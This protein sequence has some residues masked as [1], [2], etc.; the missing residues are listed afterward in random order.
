M[1][2][3]EPGPM[4]TFTASTPASNQIL[5]SL[6][7]GN[8]ARDHVDRPLLLNLPHRFDDV[9]RVTVGTV[10]DQHVHILLDQ[11]RGPLQIEHTD[12]RPNTQAALLV[13]ASLGEAVHHVDVAHGD[14]PCQS[15]IFVN[16]QKLLHLF[17][18]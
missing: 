5:R 17:S 1:V 11:T 9:L 18:R 3:I 16:Q 15:V 10:H 7:R 6:G 14:Q 13:F 8:V 4:P 2:Q 12:G